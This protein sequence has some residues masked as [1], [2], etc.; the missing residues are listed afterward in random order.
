MTFKDFR[1]PQL[2]L[3]TKTPFHYL[4]IGKGINNHTTDLLNFSCLSKL[5]MKVVIYF[6]SL[7]L[8]SVTAIPRMLLT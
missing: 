5:E 2:A 6:M 1:L 3:L 8:V 4:E 7:V